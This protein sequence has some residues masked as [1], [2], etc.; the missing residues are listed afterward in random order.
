MHTDIDP[1]PNEEGTVIEDTGGARWFCSGTQWWLIGQQTVLTADQLA[2]MI[3][4]FEVMA[5]P[6]AYIEMVLHEWEAMTRKAT[7]QAVIARMREEYP[8]TLNA[9]WSDGLDRIASEFEVES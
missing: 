9:Q 2:D 6:I 7:A 1:L 4:G 3:T 5:R 8:D